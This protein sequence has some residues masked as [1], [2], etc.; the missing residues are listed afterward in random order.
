MGLLD[1]L[2]GG[3]AKEEVAQCQHDWE[4]KEFPVMGMKLLVCRVCQ[5]ALLELHGSL[6]K[7]WKPETEMIESVAIQ[8]G[9]ESCP[10]SAP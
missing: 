10:L 4:V 6:W 9:N 3:K 2:F 8:E 5:E 1:W 7:P